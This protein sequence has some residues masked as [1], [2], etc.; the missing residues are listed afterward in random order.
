M[1]WAKKCSSKSKFKKRLL[2]VEKKHLTTLFFDKQIW[3]SI[4]QFNTLLS[5]TICQFDKMSSLMSGF[6]ECNSHFLT[7]FLCI[8]PTSTQVYTG[9]NTQELLNNMLLCTSEHKTKCVKRNGKKTGRALA[10]WKTIK[11]FLCVKNAA[12]LYHTHLCKC[13]HIKTNYPHIKDNPCLFF[14]FFFFFTISE[15]VLFEVDTRETPPTVTN[16]WAYRF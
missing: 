12:T 9:E 4:C 11:L 13:T 6:A 15:V 7:H 5:L 10:V 14:F 1:F 16:A 8:L 3:S 2:K